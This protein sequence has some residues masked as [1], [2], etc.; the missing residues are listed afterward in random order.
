MHADT[1][2]VAIVE[3]IERVKGVECRTRDL[4]ASGQTHA[5]V[6][7]RIVI[8]NVNFT[9][10]ATVPTVC[11]IGKMEQSAFKL[12]FVKMHMDKPDAMPQLSMASMTFVKYDTKFGKG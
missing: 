11:V 3:G 2:A 1:E 4:E 5:D 9:F 8:L 6:L 10:L 12:P 7:R